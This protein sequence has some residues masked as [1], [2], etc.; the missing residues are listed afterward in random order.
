MVCAVI[1]CKSGR[2]WSGN[3]RIRSIETDAVPVPAECLGWDALEANSAD[4]CG[5][6]GGFAQFAKH[7]AS[8]ARP[9][10]RGSRPH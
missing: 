7:C 2:E 10:I 5:L 4:E 1:T 3:E 9:T 6:R 8:K